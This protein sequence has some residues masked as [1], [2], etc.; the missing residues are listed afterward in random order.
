MHGEQVINELGEEI[1]KG[2]G[3]IVLDLGCYFP[4][5]NQDILTFRFSFGEEE[6]GLYK[7]NHRY[8]NNG[9]V[10]ISKKMG[11]RL[12]KLGYPLFVNLDEEI[13]TLLTIDL[14]IK[15][16]ILSYI[17]PVKVKLTKEKP[18]CSLSLNFRFNGMC[19]NF[20]SYYKCEDGWKYTIW[21]NYALED[22]N[23]IIFDNPTLAEKTFV[24]HNVLTPYPQALEDLLIL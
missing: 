22:K 3:C 16:K 18:V 20:A 15:D 2:K 10:T 11:R 7:C 24:Y 17:F 9:Y 21:A 12:S 23:V 1:S 19:F 6:Q 14:G 4:C 5:L 8:P 13:S